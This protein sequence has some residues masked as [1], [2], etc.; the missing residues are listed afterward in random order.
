MLIFLGKW[1]PNFYLGAEDE[2]TTLKSPL[3]GLF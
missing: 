1:P 2:K 3:M